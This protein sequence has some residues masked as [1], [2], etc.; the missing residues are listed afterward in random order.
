MDITEKIKTFLTKLQGLSENKKII[1]LWAV[2][3]VIG[4]PMG[5]FWV[6]GAIKNLSKIGESIGSVK[7]PEIN[8][9]DMPELP[10]LDILQNVTLSNGE[11]IK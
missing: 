3:V 10:S 1:I 7:L 5:F 8:T 2:V 9:S 6:K 4:L 11:L